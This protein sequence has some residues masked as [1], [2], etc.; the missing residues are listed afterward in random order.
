MKTIAVINL[1]DIGD[2]INSAPVCIEIKK[3]CPQAKLVFITIKSSVETAKCIPGVDEVYVFDRR[4]EHKGFLKLV[5]Q[6]LS[7]GFKEKID[8]VLVLN[9]TFRCALFSFFLGAKKRIGRA[10]QGRNFFLTHT[11]PFTK[12]EQVF[13]VHISEQLMRVLKPLNLYNPDYKSGFNFSNEDKIYIEEILKE[14]G[15][16]K[17]KLIGF[18]PCSNDPDRDWIP[19]EGAKFINHI[20]QSSDKK[21]VIIGN[22]VTTDYIKKLKKLGV[23]DFLDLTCKT[24]IAQLGTIVSMLSQMI[25]VNTGPA[26]LSYAFNIPTLTLFFHDNIVKWGPKDLIKNRIIYNPEGIKAEEVINELKTL[27]EKINTMS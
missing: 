4:G 26:H 22:M 1:G 8:T 7:I 6:A 20:N 11:I 16:F 9:E 18:C 27:P 21:I 13:G 10:C 17:Y 15:Y 3:N 19:E 24:S 5:K 2:I 23:E 14:T 12:E 25:S